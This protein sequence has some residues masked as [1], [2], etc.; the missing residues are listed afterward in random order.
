ML[1]KEF[2]KILLIMMIY[3]HTQTKH[4][5]KSLSYLV[6]SFSQHSANKLEE[7]KMVVW[8]VWGGRGVQLLL[9]R[10]AEQIQRRIEHACNRFL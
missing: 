9:F 1:F 10:H 8:D 7:C 3:E 4:F 5:Q 2:A 6:D